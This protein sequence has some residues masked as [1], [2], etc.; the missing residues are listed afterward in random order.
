MTRFLVFADA[1]ASGS[2]DMVASFLQSPLPMVLFMFAIMYFLV[3]RPQQKKQKEHEDLVSKLQKND[4][5]IT[6]GGIH[7]TIVGVSDK[8]ATVRIAD[9]VKIEMDKSH[10]LQKK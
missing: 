3:I 1:A 7:G 9:N 8:T 6:S 4:E 10:I 5:V 2:S